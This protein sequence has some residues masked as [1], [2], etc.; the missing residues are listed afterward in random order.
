MIDHLMDIEII[1]LVIIGIWCFMRFI[2]ID[3]SGVPVKQKH[4]KKIGSIVSTE[5][6]IVAF[7]G[8]RLSNVRYNY[9]NASEITMFIIETVGFLIIIIGSQFIFAAYKTHEETPRWIMRISEFM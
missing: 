5:G 7:F 4:L 9:D 2:K 3:K 8:P 6:A 1:G